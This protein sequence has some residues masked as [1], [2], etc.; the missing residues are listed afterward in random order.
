MAIKPL[1]RSIRADTCTSLLSPVQW[2]T[3]LIDI[4]A[5]D[6]GW[7]HINPSTFNMACGIMNTTKPRDRV[8]AN[9]WLNTNLD[10]NLRR[11]S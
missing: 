3:L 11:D 2:A 6:N 7:E 10:A 1:P 9:R 8:E 5:Y 4:V